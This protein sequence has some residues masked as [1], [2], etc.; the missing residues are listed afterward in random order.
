MIVNGVVYDTGALVAAERNDRKM[1][2]LHRGFIVEDVT[3]IVPA[4]VLAQAWRGGTGRQV[5]MARLIKGCTID[6]LNG[7]RAKGI[8]SIIAQVDH[9]DIV[10]VSVVET[11][12]RHGLAIVTSDVDDITAICDLLTFRTQI[13]S[14]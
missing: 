1:W 7:D 3:P 11:A 10:D 14:V 6:D 9:P 5:S 13:A 4:A 8:G 2:E 12:I